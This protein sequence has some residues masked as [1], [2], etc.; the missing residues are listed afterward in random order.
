[1]TKE[2]KKLYFTQT[3]ILSREGW[4][5]GIFKNL[6][7]KE[8]LIKPNPRYRNATPMKLFLI[9][10]IKKI[11]KSQEFKE[12][13]EKSKTRRLAAKKAVQ[14]KIN[15]TLEMIENFKIKVI[16]VKDVISEAIESYNSFQ[17]Y[18]GSLNFACKSS[19]KHFLD[20]ITVNYIR[21][22]LTQYD[23]KLYALIGKVGK[24]QAYRLLREKIFL[25]IM[26]KY[27]QYAEECFRQLN[28][29]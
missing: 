11:E 18:K 6:N 12:A 17:S 27:P 10:R 28:T 29:K 15:N 26:K 4:T 1:V 3:E 13:V 2:K 20:R 9:K 8:D 22:E 14:T 23:E 24:A 21:H 25:K 19:D 16:K 5:K 7:L